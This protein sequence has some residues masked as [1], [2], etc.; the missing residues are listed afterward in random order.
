MPWPRSNEPW[1]RQIQCNLHAFEIWIGVNT[2]AH[3]AMDVGFA[4]GPQTG[5]G[6]GG[7]LTVGA[8]NRDGDSGNNVYFNGSGTLPSDGMAFVVSGAAPQQGN[9]HTV[10]FSAH[11]V[12]SGEYVNYGELSS[13]IFPGSYVVG[14]P[15]EVV[16]P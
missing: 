6:N 15:G 10:T 11:G 2:D 13:D 9:G 5:N 14:F 3:P 12:A 7:S 8:E 4:Y 1:L 16:A